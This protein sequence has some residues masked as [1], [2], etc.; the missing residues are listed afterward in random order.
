MELRWLIYKFP[1]CKVEWKKLQC[2]SFITS[3][4]GRF[5]GWE[6]WKDVP[7]VHSENQKAYWK[8]KEKE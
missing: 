6:E 3:A 8:G 7:E 2:R 5:S 1:Q 4:D